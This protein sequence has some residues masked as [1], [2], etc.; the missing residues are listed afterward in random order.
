MSSPFNDLRALLADLP[1]PAGGGPI[2][3]N[4]ALGRLGQVAAWLSTWSGRTP[5]TVTRPVIAI[6]AGAN[7]VAARSGAATRSRL[8]AIAAGGAVVNA[9]A[10][11]Q[12]AG[13]D[14]FD[15]ALDRPT[16]DIV[17][18]AA[19]SDRACAGT[20]AFGME[21]LAK[22]PDLLLVDAIGEGG[23]IAS[24]ALAHA[25]HGGEPGDW[26]RPEEAELVG[27]AVA[28]AGEGGA[29]E[30]LAQL[31][32]REIAAAVGAIVAARVQRVPVILDGYGAAAAVAVLKAERPGAVDHCLAG[33]VTSH[34][35]HRRL[36]E[37]IG[38]PPLLDLGLDAGEGAG[39]A[40]ALALAKL[41]CAA[42]PLAPVEPLR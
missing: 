1:G 13:L 17:R 42:A 11:L 32:G 10:Q 4:P 5:P 37:R 31:G 22:T 41:A 40:A 36:L 25:L 26:C 24:A 21:A 20:V 33:N 34:P 12:G 38:L 39:A 18:Q 3:P 15:L 30:R 14:A 6:Y 27:A 9:F 7:G 2:S 28:R 29:L 35:G 16:P 8:E 19:M 23:E